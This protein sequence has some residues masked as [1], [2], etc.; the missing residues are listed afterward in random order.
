MSGTIP[1][2]QAS[3]NLEGLAIGVDVGGTKIAAGLVALDS[4]AVL[5]RQSISTHA[6]RGGAAVLDD[7]VS[8]AEALIA[9]ASARGRQVRGIG[10]GVPELVDLAGNITSGHAIAWQG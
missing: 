7:V 6:A 1:G 10:V 3:P 4:G 2:N 9:H 5:E 8:I